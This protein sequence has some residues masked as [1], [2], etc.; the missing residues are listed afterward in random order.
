M[1]TEHT[2]S[3]RSRTGHRVTGPS[4]A[5]H[6]VAGSAGT[7]RARSN[8]AAHGRGWLARRLWRAGLAVTLGGL[9]AATLSACG[10]GGSGS[11]IHA[12]FSNAENLY[13]GNPVTV[14]GVREGT[15]TKVRPRGGE[16]VVTLQLDPG[17]RVPADVQATLSNPQ[18][19]GTPA[20]DLY[21]GY[22]SGPVLPNGG[23]IPEQRTVVPISINRLLVDLQRVLG[24]INPKAV[25]GA[26]SSLSQDLT[27]QGAGLNRLIAQGAGT[28]QLL[29]DKGNQLGQLN[30]SLAAITGTLR[31]QTGQ[32]TTLLQDYDTVA[33]VL[34]ANRQPL[35]DAISALADMSQQLATL[36]SPNL[37]PLQQDIATITQ[38]GRTLDRNLPTLDQSL[39]AGDSLFAATNRAYDPV[40]NWI[41]LNLQPAGQLAS[42]QATG[43]VRDLLASI[44]RRIAANHASGLSSSELS[45]LQTCGNPSSGFFDP[46]LGLVPSL[47]SGGVNA[48]PTPQQMLADGMAAI[49]G[50]SASQRNQLSHVTPSQLSTGS[51]TAGSSA[52]GTSGTSGSSA[53][54]GSTASANQSTLHPAPPTAVPSGGSGLVG[55]LLHGL[56]GAIHVIGGLL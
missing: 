39:A 17:V 12:V 34:A 15:V 30:T 20:V 36:L 10:S 45:T 37:Q 8:A 19:L 28:L 5:E 16:V 23:T 54:P 29:A 33:G 47:L 27:N 43:L 18:V 13:S 53:G 48:G 51:S 52:A 46:I 25:S 44:C 3:Q 7:G 49:P 14:L 21:P 31:Q 4:V 40:H 32:V 6:V 42:G 35:A 2:I 9:C 26:V 38:L 1:P 24:E 50:L 41:N 55:D 11:T 22:T 56:F